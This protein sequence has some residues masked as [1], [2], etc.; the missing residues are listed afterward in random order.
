MR[1]DSTRQ[2]PSSLR[3][4]LW[5]MN[6]YVVAASRSG[7]GHTKVLFSELVRWG[8]GKQSLRLGLRPR[9]RISPDAATLRAYLARHQ[10]LDEAPV[11][12]SWLGALGRLIPAAGAVAIESLLDGAL[13]ERLGPDVTLASLLDGLRRE[14]REE[15][16]ALARAIAEPL[17]PVAPCLPLVRRAAGQARSL[18]RAFGLGLAIARGTGEPYDAH[19]WLA[20]LGT[21][22]D[23]LV[24]AFAHSVLLRIVQTRPT[25]VVRD[26]LRAQA[27]HERTRHRVQVLRPTLGLQDRLYHPFV[28]AA[29]AGIV[30]DGCEQLGWLHECLFESLATGDLP[31]V[32]RCLR[33]CIWLGIFYP[34]QT[35]RTLELLPPRLPFP[36][37]DWLAR[38][39]AIVRPRQPRLVRD[40]LERHPS[41][42]PKVDAAA[43]A[44][45]TARYATER[46]WGQLLAGALARSP[47]AR[48]ALA[49]TLRLVAAGAPFTAIV[50]A[51]RGGE[52]FDL[53]V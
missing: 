26:A 51:A 45:W 22:R 47:A 48:L 24:R 5:R 18:A 11:G 7:A 16:E 40:L 8:D 38:T 34:A 12:S 13:R 28:P 42:A 1:L 15:V 21:D 31:M 23:P 25:T 52:G 17:A 2:T 6:D 20:P 29:V 53:E 44:L 10:R 30:V 39:L 33:E 32:E 27:N 41:L 14:P 35:A 50:D 19:E 46:E 4:S 3:R 43:D 36:V 37:D 49:R 9:A